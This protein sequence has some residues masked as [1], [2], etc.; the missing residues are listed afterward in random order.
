MAKNISRKELKRPDEFV[1]FWTRI[2][3]GAGD[4]FT[5]RKRAIVIGVTA[6]AT[7]I[8]GSIIFSAMAERKA[9]RASHALE[10]V[11]K[12]AAAD[13]TP[14][15]APAKDDGLPHFKTEKERL[16]AALKELDGFLNAEPR[17]PLAAEARLE[18]GALLLAL[19]RADEAITTYQQVLGGKLDDRL[20]FLA[21]EG[22]GYAYEQK[23]DL[24]KAQAAF[25]QL[26]QLKGDSSAMA[27]AFKDRALYQKARIAELKGNRKDATKLYQEVLDKNPNTSLRDEVTNR[28]A[29][30]ELK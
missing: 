13:L 21:H 27:A 19:G 18:R 14:A 26:G 16:E 11:H 29:A 1:S 9:I 30:L 3:A 10:R 15:G 4:F 24:D 8:V 12:I 5:I 6:L 7:V 2:A 23:G 17:N 28:L 20:R 22:L 25:E